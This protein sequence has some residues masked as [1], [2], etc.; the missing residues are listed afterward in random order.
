MK[1]AQMHIL[2][3]GAS[4]GIGQ[5]AARRLA[6]AGARIIA[7]GRHQQSLDQLLAELA[8]VDSGEHLA[9]AAD[10]SDELARAALLTQLMG[11]EQPPNVL[12]NMAGT[13]QLR[14]F[15][16]QDTATIRSIID[17]N[18]T[19]T[20]LLTHALLPLLRLR[21]EALIVNVGSTLGSIGYPGYVAY[22]SSKFALRGFTEAL[23][24]ELSDS[25]IRVKYFAPRATRTALNAGAADALN[26]ELRTPVDSPDEVAAALLQFIS[27]TDSQRFL[28][29]PEKLFVR[30]NGLFPGL[31]SGSIK[32]QLD[33]IK[34]HAKAP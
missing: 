8:P 22:S 14:L 17:T 33:T 24:R 23:G 16:Q 25:P 19:H 21:L 20:L 5:V 18:F 10:L 32:K 2:L 11:L 27:T 15:E 31:V 1:P 7:V 13:N 28:G 29:W 6:A 34:V 12:I 9:L 30:L 4:G 3:T 26:A